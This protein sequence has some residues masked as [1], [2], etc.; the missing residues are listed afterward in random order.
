MSISK[1]EIH[2]RYSLNKIG[3]S[4]I[5]ITP[6]ASKL[7]R[8]L[9]RLTLQ[10]TADFSSIKRNQL[11]HF[12][13]EGR[14]LSSR[15]KRWL[16]SMFESAGAEFFTGQGQLHVRLNG[17]AVINFG[18]KDESLRDLPIGQGCRAERRKRKWSQNRTAEFSGVSQVRI[19]AIENRRKD[20]FYLAD[21]LALKNTFEQHQ[22]LH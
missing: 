18:E 8:G 6:E 3:D 1:A 9:L 10:R 14:P 17:Q 21:Q 15:N 4:P 20:K 7:L 12:E 2:D 19:S 11:E 22:A 16:Q 13:N 5:L